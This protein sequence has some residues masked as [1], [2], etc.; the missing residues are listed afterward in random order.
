MS[1]DFIYISLIKSV[2]ML[3]KNRLKITLYM[4]R[5]LIF[6]L[7][8]FFLLYAKINGKKENFGIELY[9]IS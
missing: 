7:T 4:S 3:H 8:S 5:D 6:G 2:R 1:H 9:K